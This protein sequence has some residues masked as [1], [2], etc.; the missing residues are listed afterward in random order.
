MSKCLICTSVFKDDI[1][2][3][4]SSG[5]NNNYVQQWCKERQLNLSLKLIKEHKDNHL[6]NIEKTNIK[7]SSSEP[8]YLTLNNI[9]DQLNVKHK[10]LLSYF[11]T[12]NLKLNRE[13]EYDV[14]AI[15]TH[16]INQLSQKVE[17][18]TKDLE[19]LIKPNELETLT[20]LKHDKLT[21]QVRLQNAVADLKQIKLK[22]AQRE[23][24]FDQELEEQWSYSLVGFKAKLESIPNKVALELSS[25]SNKSYV[26]NVLTKL[27]SE[28]LSELDNGSRTT[29]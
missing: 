7:L 19:Q 4:I 20:R 14:I 17:S 10:E 1:D 18:L 27:I 11:S 25:I 13:Q 23:L 8:I 5:S 9:E 24:V 22:Q 3:M 2:K 6:N 28:A 21:E 12:N 16:L 29:V 15:M 26:Q